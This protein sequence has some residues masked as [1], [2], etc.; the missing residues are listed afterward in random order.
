MHFTHLYRSLVLPTGCETFNED[1]KRQLNFEDYQLHQWLGIGRNWYLSL[2]AY[3]LLGYQ[4]PQRRL[5]WQVK[6]QFHS[7]SQRCQAVV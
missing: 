2:I 6:A 4:A 5:Y 7:I 3:S 1:V